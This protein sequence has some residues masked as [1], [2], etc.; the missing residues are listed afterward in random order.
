MDYESLPNY[1]V[2]EA[3]APITLRPSFRKA[4][5]DRSGNALL[6]LVILIIVI[7]P[8]LYLRLTMTPTVPESPARPDFERAAGNFT[9]VEGFM[10]VEKVEELLG[11]PSGVPTD[12]KWAKW[13][14]GWRQEFGRRP[15]VSY[16]REWA[17]PTDPERR[18]VIYFE[19]HKV[20]LRFQIGI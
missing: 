10:D 3:P 1:P 11:P 15:Q 9:R 20:V 19:D 4:F 16:W 2:V 14:E 6:K 7:G 18:I 8:V 17:D 12:S 13:E 5:W